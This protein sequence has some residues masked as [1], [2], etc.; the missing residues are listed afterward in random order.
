MPN[1]IEAGGLVKDW[2]LTNYP[3]ALDATMIIGL[4]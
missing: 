2:R 3:D 1:S 4:I